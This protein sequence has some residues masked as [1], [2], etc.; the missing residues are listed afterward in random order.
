MKE[1]CKGQG[2]MGDKREDKRNIWWYYEIGLMTVNR[3]VNKIWTNIYRERERVKLYFWVIK[4]DHIKCWIHN[5]WM[6][7]QS[8]TDI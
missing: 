7:I 3:N 6:T 4:S 2:E 1:G 5:S 8:F